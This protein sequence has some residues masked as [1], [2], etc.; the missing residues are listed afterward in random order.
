MIELF[1]ENH[2][3]G[4]A[5]LALT[6]EDLND[7][8]GIEE[9]ENS[10]SEGQAENYEFPG[11]FEDT[12]GNQ[13]QPEHL[14]MKHYIIKILAEIK[15]LKIV[16]YKTLKRMKILDDFK[17]TMNEMDILAEIEL[18]GSEFDEAG[19][20]FLQN[21][22]NEQT[23]PLSTGNQSMYKNKSL[24]QNNK[25]V[26]FINRLAEKNKKMKTQKEKGVYS[27]SNIS[28]TQS[29][30]NDSNSLMQFK[31]ENHQKILETQL[32]SKNCDRDELE[33]KRDLQMKDID[34]LISKLKIA[35]F[36]IPF[37]QIELIATNAN[38]S[39]VGK[40]QNG[41]YVSLQPRQVYNYFQM[42]TLLQEVQILSK[43][44]HPNL[45]MHLGITYMEHVQ[46]DLEN[47]AK[48]T[49]YKFYMVIENLEFQ[50]QNDA[51]KDPKTQTMLLS[52]YI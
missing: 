35:D 25:H 50:H 20:T 39:I 16:W 7:I 18:E 42:Q 19:S 48:V 8:F 41:L 11:Q 23:Y 3:D 24:G 10:D 9:G 15:K 47:D 52:Q 45:E 22:S 2:I 36:Y 14:Q 51:T 29:E 4:Y 13:E 40:W 38:Q 33:I 21:N 30:Q 1:V 17:D 34:I 37:D 32:K 28:N 43:I 49:N 31:A 6:K 27:M 44:R 5:L 12:F 26:L 46:E